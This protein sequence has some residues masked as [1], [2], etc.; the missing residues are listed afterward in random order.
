MKLKLTSTLP[1]LISFIFLVACGGSKIGSG[2]S[3]YGLNNGTLDPSRPI[4][5]RFA[6]PNGVKSLQ[7][8]VTKRLMVF[9][10]LG[11]QKDHAEIKSAFLYQT[12]RDGYT[13]SVTS[14]SSN[15]TRDGLL[16]EDPIA[17]LLKDVEIVFHVLGNGQI[18]DIQGYDKVEEKAQTTLSEDLKP[19]LL[20]ALREETLKSKDITEWNDKI[21]HFAGSEVSIGESF[22][23]AVPFALPNG[24]IVVCQMHT[25]IARLEACPPGKC[26][27]IEIRYN[28]DAA[29]STSLVANS[30]TTFLPESSFVSDTHILGSASRLIDPNTMLI[31][32]EKMSRTIK[33]NTEIPGMGPIP[34]TVNESR[35]Y[36]FE[37]Q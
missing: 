18:S 17:K 12:T 14:K 28:S 10:G 16:G 8:I 23:Q 31:Y 9:D 26:V 5:F 34:T 24:M 21:A 33:M 25:T 35:S 3:P 27:R 4:K 20:P 37:Y 32:S 36:T 19:V 15:M 13:I 29:E 7:T 11:E 6:P 2:D 30:Q 22:Q 1:I